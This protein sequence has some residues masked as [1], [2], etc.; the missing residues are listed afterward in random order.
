[1]HAFIWRK[2]RRMM[3]AKNKST[4]PSLAFPFASI[5]NKTDSFTEKSRYALWRVWN[6][7][8]MLNMVSRR[9]PK[10]SMTQFIA[11]VDFYGM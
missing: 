3:W 11:S 6:K 4:T 9:F 2:G 10:H 1:M 8:D 7:E 5:L